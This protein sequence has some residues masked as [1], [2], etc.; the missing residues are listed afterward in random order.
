MRVVGPLLCLSLLAGC[1]F[2]VEGIDVDA[3]ARGTP[4]AARPVDAAIGDADLPPSAD[5]LSDAGPAAVDFPPMTPASAIGRSASA[6]TSVFSSSV[7]SNPSKPRNF[8]PFLARRTMILF[9]RILS[10][11]KACSGWPHSKST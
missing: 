1:S 6:M 9:P 5:D 8:S 3:G 10:R 11:S 2:V 7:Y 4:D